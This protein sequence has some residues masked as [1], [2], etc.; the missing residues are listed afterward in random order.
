MSDNRP[1]NNPNQPRQVPLLDLPRQQAEFSA[2]IDEAL[3]RVTSGAAYILGPEVKML[4][5]QLASYLGVAHCS[6]VASGT[7]ALVI[8][9]RALAIVR[10]GKEYFSP[11]DEVIVPSFTFTASGEAVLHAGATPVFV[12]IDP[13]TFNINPD[14]AAA[15]VNSHSIGLMPVH[16]F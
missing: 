16:L 2:E 12:D 4:E 15:A 6:G 3:K 10:T 9:L 13:A 8:A 1:A 7:D 5:Q 11:D 14:S